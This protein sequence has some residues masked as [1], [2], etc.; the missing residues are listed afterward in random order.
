MLTASMT[1]QRHMQLALCQAPHTL[2]PIQAAHALEE[3]ELPVHPLRPLFVAL[4]PGDTPEEWLVAAVQDGRVVGR[5]A[6]RFPTNS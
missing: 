6:W 2:G 4:E 3:R 1:V 5:V